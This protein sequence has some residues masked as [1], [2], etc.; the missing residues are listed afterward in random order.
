MTI[1]VSVITVS[2]NAV[3]TIRKTLES[4]KNIKDEEVQFIIIDGNSND[5]TLD[6]ISEYSAI[7]D[8]IISEPDKGIYDAMNKG[9]SVATGR[10]CL[11]IG[12]D[13]LLIKNGFKES[14]SFLKR[15]SGHEVIYGNVIVGDNQLEKITSKWK[16]LRENISHQAIFYPK[17]IYSAHKYNIKYRICADHEYNIR[18]IGHNVKY[19]HIP[20]TVTVFGTDG[21]SSSQVDSDFQNDYINLVKKNSSCVHFY[22][23]YLGKLLKRV[24]VNGFSGLTSNRNR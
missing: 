14:V 9:L 6:V 17:S 10:F 2:F 16:I 7:V 18:L 3:K 4:V 8:I 20:C 21:I 23:I 19:K 5:G 1:Q 12:A 13:D 22:L 11:F 24:I 15:S